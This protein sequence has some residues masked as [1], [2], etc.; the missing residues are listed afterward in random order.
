MKWHE[1]GLMKGGSVRID[2]NNVKSFKLLKKE[3]Y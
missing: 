3:Y 2:R 1:T